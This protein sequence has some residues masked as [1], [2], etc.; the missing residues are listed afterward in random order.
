MYF[1]LTLGYPLFPGE[2]EF[3]QLACMMEKLGMP[4]W[5]MIEGSRVFSRYFAVSEGTWKYYNPLDKQTPLRFIP[6][7]CTIHQNPDG[8]AELRSNLSRKTHRLRKAPGA[9]QISQALVSTL[10]HS[11]GKYNDYTPTSSEELDNMHVVELIKA[12]L[13]WQPERRITPS[14]AKTFSW[15]TYKTNQPGD[16]LSKTLLSRSRSPASSKHSSSSSYHT[17]HTDITPAAFKNMLTNGNL[18]HAIPAQAAV[19]SSAAPVAD[20]R[21]PSP[22]KVASLAQAHSNNCN[23]HIDS[24]S[25][26]DNNVTASNNKNTV[27]S[28]VKISVTS[29]SPPGPEILKR[30][31]SL[32]SISSGENKQEERV[33]YARAYKPF[34]PKST[35]FEYN[36]GAYRQSNNSTEKKMPDI[37][38][39]SLDSSIDEIAPRLQEN[40][41]YTRKNGA[42]VN[43]RYL[44]TSTRLR[45]RNQSQEPKR[46]TQPVG[47]E[48]VTKDKSILPSRSYITSLTTALSSSPEDG[49]EKSGRHNPHALSKTSQWDLSTIDRSESKPN[50]ISSDGDAARARKGITLRSES[51]AFGRNKNLAK[52]RSAVD[53]PINLSLDNLNESERLR[54]RPVYEDSLRV[55]PMRRPV[56]KE[57]ILAF[58][59]ADTGISISPKQHLKANTAKNYGA[60]DT[61]GRIMQ[62]H[63]DHRR[64]RLTNKFSSANHLVELTEAKLSSSRSS[65][66]TSIPRIHNTRTNGAGVD[67]DN[68]FMDLNKSQPSIMM[69]KPQT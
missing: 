57:Q 42:Q 38:Y 48:V 41:R 15:F 63:G 61:S 45:K 55:E 44:E 1:L 6:K 16:N 28:K 67:T 69:V 20:V 11:S 60:R 53:F 23:K 54:R 4:P 66:T 3:D 32:A 27:N 65:N 9:V 5:Q 2:D 51:L 10:S 64:R 43:E 50:Y 24:T 59:P 12:C 13:A 47:T 26:Y 25:D 17:L 52:T 62:A 58:K 21:I 8:T 18:P 7:Y 49:S 56:G 35:S 33:I 39:P 30:H 29:I 37:A 34:S 14:E 46:H 31:G 68:G 19:V 36:A 22:P 40:A